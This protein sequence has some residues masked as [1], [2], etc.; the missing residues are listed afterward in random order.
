MTF[1]KLRMLPINLFVSCCVCVCSLNKMRWW[2][3]QGPEKRTRR[4]TKSD[5]I[6]DVKRSKKDFIKIKWQQYLQVQ[7]DARNGNED[8]SSVL[9]M[10]NT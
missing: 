1:P 3:V 4:E 5:K 9:V 8:E 6:I 2:W 7:R 10:Q